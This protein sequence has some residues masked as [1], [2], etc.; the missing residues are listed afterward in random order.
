MNHDSVPR[1]PVKRSAEADAAQLGNV[2][3]V[4]HV[5]KKPRPLPTDPNAFEHYLFELLLFKAK[6]CKFAVTREED[7]CLHQ[8]LQHLKREYK[9]YTQDPSSTELVSGPTRTPRYASSSGETPELDP[10]GYYINPFVDPSFIPSHTQNIHNLSLSL[11][12]F[13][14]IPKTYSH[15]CITTIL[16]P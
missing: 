3:G 10:T 15:M 6:H 8:W 4:T 5:S 7:A 16:S 2:L 12:L 13:P 11:S 14:V 9:N 1:P